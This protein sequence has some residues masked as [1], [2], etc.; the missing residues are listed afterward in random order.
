MIL[1][2]MGRIPIPR[3]NIYA[4]PYPKNRVPS[5][6]AT[7]PVGLLCQCNQVIRQQ[8]GKTRTDQ[9]LTRAFIL[10]LQSL[11]THVITG[12]LTKLIILGILLWCFSF[13]RT[14]KPGSQKKEEECFSFRTHGRWNLLPTGE[15]PEGCE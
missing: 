5:E 3:V 4:I 10:W 15:L 14:Q 1:W 12:S 2:G 11:S 8:K 7:L 13:P 9:L 6:Q